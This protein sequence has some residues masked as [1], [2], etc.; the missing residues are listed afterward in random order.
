MRR[1]DQFFVTSIR[2][3]ALQ[4][5]PILGYLNRV[6]AFYRMQMRGLPA[7]SPAVIS[8]SILPPPEPCG[9]VSQ[10]G[11]FFSRRAKGRYQPGM[12]AMNAT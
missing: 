12:D 10:R 6:P 9:V 3:A 1:A 2:T 11:N 5:A 8:L 4:G 7:P